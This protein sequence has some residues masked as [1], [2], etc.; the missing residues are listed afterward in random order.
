MFAI[1]PITNETR[2]EVNRLLYEE[3]ACPPVVSKGRCIDTT[4]LPGFVCIEDGCIKGILTYCVES[5]ECE[6]VTLNSFEENRGIGTALIHAAMEAAK[7]SGCNRLWLITS[8]DDIRA[9]L[10]YQLRGFDLAAAYIGAMDLSRQLK[11]AIPLLGMHGIPIRHEL[12]FE[13][14]W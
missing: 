13:M 6:I 4:A 12:E 10:F 3:W 7:G 8:N 2:A 14:K 1:T 11:P 5:A 9:I